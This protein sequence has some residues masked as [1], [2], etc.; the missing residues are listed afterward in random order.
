[1][2]KLLLI[3]SLLLILSGCASPYPLG[4]DKTQ[5]NALTIEERHS[6]LLKQQQ[7]REEQRLAQIKADAQ[8]RKLRIEQEMAE[9]RR[10]EKLYSDPRNGNIVMVNLL[11]GE[12]RAGKRSKRLIEATYQ[13]ARGETK[14]IELILEDSKT[15]YSSTETAYLSYD[16]SGNGVYLTLDNPSYDS[17]YN[18]SKRIALLRDGHWP[19]GSNYT[20]SLQGA[21]EQLLGVR[22]FVKESGSSCRSSQPP[23]RRF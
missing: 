22:A 18:P 11:G 9:S 8:T 13:I 17:S 7:Y 4:M 5:W 16:A 19:C 2:K 21:Y 14:K 15:H 6:L 3:T 23:Y 12:Y 1:M 10:L 20:K